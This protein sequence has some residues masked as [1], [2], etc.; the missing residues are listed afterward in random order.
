MNS[1]TIKLCNY[2]SKLKLVM[3]DANKKCLLLLFVLLHVGS[4]FSQKL[5]YDNFEGIKYINY[6]ERSGVLDTLTKNPKIDAVNKSLKCAFYIRNP[7]KKFDNIK[8]ELPEKLFNVNEYATYLGE[9][10]K[11]KMKVYT[12]A[13]AGTLIEILLGSKS[14]NNDYPAG[15][16]S[17]Y[18]VYTSVT[19][20]W[21]ELEFK[22]SQVPTGSET[23]STQIDQITLLF[24]PNSS[25]SDN[26]YFDEITG[27]TLAIEKQDQRVAP[28]EEMKKLEVKKNKNNIKEYK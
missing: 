23:S 2:V 15:T 24:N 18:Q 12:T 20:S 27:P 22:F 16:N 17:Q 9:P 1:S 4:T 26:Y 7:V 11:I 6:G 25:T 3:N 19:N 5:M 21:E 8:M 28:H 14:G 13:P 10:A